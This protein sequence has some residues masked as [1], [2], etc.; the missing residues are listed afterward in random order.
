M[1]TERPSLLTDLV[2]PLFGVDT[3]TLFSLS[4]EMSNETPCNDDLIEVR[5]KEITQQLMTN[6]NEIFTFGF[7]IILRL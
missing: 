3:G 4:K 2:I 1:F 5:I 7:K 6:N